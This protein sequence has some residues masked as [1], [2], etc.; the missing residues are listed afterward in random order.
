MYLLCSS[1]CFFFFFFLILRRPPRSTR[2]V[3]LFPY[4]PLFRSVGGE[5]ASVTA[6]VDV[7]D[8]DGFDFIEIGVHG[9]APIGIDDARVKS[10][11][12]NGGYTGQIGRAHV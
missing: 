6:G 1:V 9:K 8:V 3:T 7:D 2:T 12:Q 11:P 4:T 5:V 10:H